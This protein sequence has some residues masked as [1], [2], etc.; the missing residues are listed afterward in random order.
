MAKKINFEILWANN[1]DGG[2]VLPIPVPP[3]ILSLLLQH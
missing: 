2:I 3:L 1:E